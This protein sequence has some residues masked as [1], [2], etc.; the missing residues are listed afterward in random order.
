MPPEDRVCSHHADLV[1]RIAGIDKKIDQMI[2]IL[3]PRDLEETIPGRCL[4]LVG[5]FFSLV[6]PM[7]TPTVGALLASAILVATL[8]GTGL[9]LVT[10]LIEVAPGTT[11][12]TTSPGGSS[13]TGSTTT[14][15]TTTDQVPEGYPVDAPVEVPEVEVGAVLGGP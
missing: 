8:A 9:R 7:V 11:T 12:T 14:T 15:T 6:K 2:E 4:A 3:T 5:R 1:E 10:D 13:A